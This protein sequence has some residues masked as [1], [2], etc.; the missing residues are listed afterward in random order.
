MN[1][2]S[3]FVFC[4]SILPTLA[5]NKECLINP[6][7]EIKVTSS[8]QSFPI[9]IFLSSSEKLG[10]QIQFE[11]L[12]PGRDSDHLE[13]SSVECVVYRKR[14][15]VPKTEHLNCSD[16][17]QGW[18]QAQISITSTVLTI[19]QFLNHT[20]DYPISYIITSANQSSY[21]QEN[22]PKWEIADTD[23]DPIKIPLKGQT[24]V[25]LILESDEEFSPVV[26]ILGNPLSFSW[27]RDSIAISQGPPLS[28]GQYFISIFNMSNQVIL[29]LNEINCNCEVS[30]TN[31]GDLVD[32]LSISSRKG[33]FYTALNLSKLKEGPMIV[34]TVAAEVSINAVKSGEAPRERNICDTSLIVIT[35]ISVCVT[36]VSIIVCVYIVKRNIRTKPHMNL[37]FEQHPM[38]TVGEDGQTVNKRIKVDKKGVIE[39]FTQLIVQE[40]KALEKYKLMMKKDHID[41]DKKIQKLSIGSLEP[42]IPTKTILI[43]G[44]TGSGKSSTI[45]AIV[46]YLF[47]INLEDKERFLLIEN[48]IGRKIDKY[49][50]Q[51]EFMTAYV[52]PYQDGMPNNC[53]Y[54]LI[55][56]GL[57]ILEDLNEIN[58]KCFS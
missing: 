52:L 16:T 14:N 28:E 17:A 33:T 54:I 55:L 39:N 13:I 51:T 15:R 21:C 2:G 19:G 50:S 40:N 27:K 12:E 37:D 44:E 46:N 8:S 4:I 42:Y 7:K 38:I 56:L 58:K 53:N 32:E 26:H 6:I 49:E 43:L 30:I 18:Y 22:L 5:V 34:T 20:L 11:D 31:L 45:N 23:K 57:G 48:D 41:S 35:S 10:I 9:S 47:G 3:V 29:K 1:L 25:N 24:D 36:L